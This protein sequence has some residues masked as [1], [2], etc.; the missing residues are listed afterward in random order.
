MRYAHLLSRFQ[1]TVWAI[2][3]ATLQALAT[4]LQARIR[5]EATRGGTPIAADA[6]GDGEESCCPPPTPGLAIIPVRGVIGKHLSQME[7]ECGA[8]DLDDIEAQLTLAQ[9]DPATRAILFLIDSPGGSAQ[10]VH[11][12]AAKIRA[13]PKPTFAFTDTQCCSGAYWLASACDLIACTPTSTL[14]CIEAYI[15][16]VNEAEA[17]SKAGLKLELIK[18]GDY[19]GIGHPGQPLAPAERALLQSHVDAIGALYRGDVALKRPQIPP[20]AMN[21][22]WFMGYEAVASGLADQVVLDLPEFLTALQ[23]PAASV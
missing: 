20:A 15:P 12:T 18:S 17:W 19:A 13:C 4:L 9:N 14:G 21:A 2:Q 16:L 23:A 5:G 1:S 8:C 3:P 7:T 6:G 11:E 22:Q 10:G